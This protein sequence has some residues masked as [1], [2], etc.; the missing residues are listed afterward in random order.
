LGTAVSPVGHARQGRP[1]MRVRVEPEGG[2]EMSE[3]VVRFGQVVL[4][5]LRAGEHA[6][7]TLRPESGFDVGF[8]GQ[9]K[10][11]ALRVA[12][13][14]LGVIIDARGRPLELS[15]DP[16]ERQELNLKWLKD[17]GALK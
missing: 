9:G 12:G 11:G 2:G 7:L 4:L 6:R 17:V 8:G 5:P 10:A 13:G 16:A 14:A 3:G 1:V 15:N